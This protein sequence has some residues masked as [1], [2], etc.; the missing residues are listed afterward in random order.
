MIILIIQYSYQYLLLFDSIFYPSAKFIIVS[1]CG[2]IYFLIISNLK[3]IS[4]LDWTSKFPVQASFYVSP[5][6]LLSCV[7]SFYLLLFIYLFIFC[8]FTPSWAAPAAYGGSQARGRI[9]AAAASL[10]WSHSNLGSEPCLQP[11]PQLM[12]IPDP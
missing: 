7:F 11:T 2:F 12:A 1:H 4:S 9:G 10:H 8:L 5:T 6:L 3:H